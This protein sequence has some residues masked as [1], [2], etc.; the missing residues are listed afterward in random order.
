MDFR[1]FPKILGKSGKSEIH[2]P[3]FC[4][5]QVLRYAHEALLPAAQARDGRREG[6]ARAAGGRGVRESDGLSANA[7]GGA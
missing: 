2:P 7:Q 1:D 6:G 3:K 5:G 4:A